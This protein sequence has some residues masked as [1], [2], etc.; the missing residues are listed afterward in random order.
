VKTVAI[1]QAR[2]A[3]T[4]L[5]GKALLP[6][7]G[8]PSAVLA[9]LRAGNQDNEILVATSSDSSDDA[10]TEQ[11][12][13]HGIRVFR[14]PLHDVLERYYLAA[15]GLANDC[16]VV[17]LSGDNVVPDGSFV[18]EL[19]AA[20]VASG[21]EYLVASSLQGRLPYGLGAEAFSVAA[22][23][24][25]RAAATSPSDREH[26]GPWIHRNCRSGIYVPQA[27]GS[28]DYSHLRCTIDDEEDYQRILRL[29][30]GVSDPLHIGWFE[31]LQKLASLPGEPRFRV[32]Y[33]V[34][35]DRPHSELTLGTAQLGMKYGIVNL[36][37][38]P[39]RSQA[40]AIVR[41]AIAH[42][43]TAVDTARSYGDAE[44]VLGEA[45]S[46][47]WQSRVQ[48]ITKLDPL[49]SLPADAGEDQVRACVDESVKES[50]QALHTRQ[51]ATLLLHRWHHH[52]SW[53]G[54][55]WRR[56][57]E[58]RDEGTI[59]A[60][61][62]S[63]YE[64]V[65]ALEALR[66]PD[67]RHLQIPMNVLDQR[68][69]ANGVKQ[70]LADRPDVVVHARSIFLQGILVHPA[71]SWPILDNYDAAASVQQLQMLARRFGRE[72]LADLCL[73][74]VRSQSWI[75][76]VVVGCETLPQIEG[77]LRLFRL[78]KLTAEQCE[79]LERTVP[80][81]PEAL[82]NPSKWNLAHEHSATQQR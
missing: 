11:F 60:L 73:A 56:L 49:G 25:A 28:A 57:L 62:V 35:C 66:D 10:L 53:G 7:A 63:V 14:G 40:V 15:D 67:I 24:R 12:G 52:H 47:A 36:A 78:P 64:P 61:G 33:R 42:G 44:Q 26:V 19:A 71:E 2:T 59:A 6:V 18:Q 75:A 82:L 72:S 51:L 39:S 22:L 17:R 8:Y 46:G 20:L 32:P 23:R 70:A 45:L 68:W 74:Y 81:A 37:G 38:K 65:E 29:F 50:C 55:V 69:K 1:M 3:S 9:A 27:L 43:V 77:N 41:E 13:S 30:D 21:V 4:R 5:Q 58:L 79:E 54:S 16:V 31:L 34:V 48:V 76:S 80:V